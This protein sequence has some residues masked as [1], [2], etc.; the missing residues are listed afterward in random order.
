MY[1]P[2]ELVRAVAINQQ[3]KSVTRFGHGESMGNQAIKF[4]LYP[5]ITK[6]A[7]DI[8]AVIEVHIEVGGNHLVPPTERRFRVYVPG[9]F[10]AFVGSVTQ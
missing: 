7:E 6:H 1:L 3:F 4:S 10:P 9:Q 8:F 2:N 5:G